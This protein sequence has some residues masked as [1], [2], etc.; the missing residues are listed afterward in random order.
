MRYEFEEIICAPKNKVEENN[1]GSRKREWL[2][3][4]VCALLCVC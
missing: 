1:A 3:K 2:G 4:Y